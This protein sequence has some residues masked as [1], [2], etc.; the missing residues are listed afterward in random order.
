MIR[1]DFDISYVKSENW[2]DSAMGLTAGTTYIWRL[3]DPDNPDADFFY[4]LDLHF[5]ISYALS[6][7]A[8]RADTQKGVKKSSIVFY[9]GGYILSETQ[10]GL[11]E[12][13]DI[14]NSIG[15][16]FK[17]VGPVHSGKY[18]YEAEVYFPK[19]SETKTRDEDVIRQMK[20][21]SDTSSDTE[22]FDLGHL[23]GV[24]EINLNKGEDGFIAGFIDVAPDIIKSSGLCKLVSG[25]SA[26]S[27]INMISDSDL[28]ASFDRFN[29][30]YEK[31]NTEKQFKSEDEEDSNP[32]LEDFDIEIADPNA[33]EKGPTEEEL[34]AIENEKINK[35]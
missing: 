22:K 6:R 31:F 14:L 33:E 24:K 11:D 18:R 12:W 32:E 17:N 28:L 16:T 5:P 4:Y 1:K 15:A 23:Q 21:A 2:E 27:F 26:N 19:Y 34:T 10:N 7:A 13:E 20:V 25:I 3:F 35:I 30:L 9:Q 8:V 29:K